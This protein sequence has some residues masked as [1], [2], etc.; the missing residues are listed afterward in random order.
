MEE[1]SDEGEFITQEDVHEQYELGEEDV[2]DVGEEMDE[3]EGGEVEQQETF[4]DDS[5]QGFFDHR[6][7][8]N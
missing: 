2:R 4:E 1:Y 7:T 3:E 5:I 8:I 6:G